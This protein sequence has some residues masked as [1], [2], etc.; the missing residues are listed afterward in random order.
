MISIV[1]PVYNVYPYLA[2]CLDSILSQSLA[3]WELILVDDGSTDGSETIC[4]EY[5]ARDERIRVIHQENHGPAKARNEGLSVCQ[6]E[7]VAFID[8]DDLLHASYFEVLLKVIEE[9]QAD[10]VQ[11][12]YVLLADQDRENYTSERLHQSLPTD[13]VIKSFAGHDAIESML[14]QREMDSSPIKLYRRVVLADYPFP[15]QF[16]AY[17]DLYA[18]LSV[19]TRCKKT[20]WV[21]LPIYYY[22]KRSNGTLNTWSVRDGRSLDLMQKVRSW[23]K[24]YDPILLP[25]VSSR[26][27]SMAFNILRLLSKKDSSC[28]SVLS[29]RCWQIVK[30]YRGELLLNSQMRLKNKLGILLSYLGKQLLIKCFSFTV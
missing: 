21:D 30:Q 5:A 11:T 3:D 14:Y 10:I 22:F 7:Y 1:I 29:D 20:C 19:Y 28:D 12:S 4:D 18:L 15:E 25:A 23:I 17:E 2:S 6:G 9:Q 8:S 16:V 26:E 24:D 27:L 13:F